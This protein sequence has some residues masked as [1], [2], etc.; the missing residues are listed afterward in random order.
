VRIDLSM[1]GGQT[2]STLS[3]DEIN[4]GSYAWTVPD[5]PTMLARIRVRRPTLMD[6]SPA[7]CSGDT[8]GIFSIAAPVMTTPGN[9]PDGTTGA[10]VTLGVAPN[11]EITV[12]WSESCSGE[13]AEYAIYEGSLD[14][15]R[16]GSWD[17]VPVTC[18][19]GTDLGET[20][21]PSPGNRFYLVTPVAGSYEGSLGE[22]SGGVDRP[23]SGAACAPRGQ[24]SCD[25]PESG[26]GENH[27]PESPFPYTDHP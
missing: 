1:N 23:L 18:S 22:S 20:I 3:A 4:D 12:E 27:T 25:V 2:W 9:V 5:D 10:P 6:S 17:H 7:S 16:A 11:G 19:A 13:A 21:T 8:G 14:T 15:L 26:S 24:T